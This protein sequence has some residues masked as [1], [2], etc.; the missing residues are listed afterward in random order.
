MEPGTKVLP[1]AVPVTPLTPPKDVVVVPPPLFT[2]KGAAELEVYAVFTTLPEFKE[3]FIELTATP[4]PE[5][6]FRLVAVAETGIPVVIVL[7]KTPA[8]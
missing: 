4:V 7:T 3:V 8:L 2:T 6:P 5:N 1:E